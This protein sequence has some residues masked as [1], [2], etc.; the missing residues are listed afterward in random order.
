MTKKKKVLKVG[1]DLDG[2]I[3][4][5]PAR[6]IRPLVSLLK[7][8]K[9]VKRKQLQFF[10]P[11]T[12]WQ[13]LMWCWFHKSSIF[14]APGLDDIRQLVEQNKIEAFIITARFAHLK[15]DFLKWQEKMKAS[16]IFTACYLNEKDEQPHLFK[17]RMIKQLKLDY[18]VE[19]NADIVDYLA[20]KMARDNLSTKIFWVYNLLDKRLKY[21]FKFAGLKKAVLAIK[22]NL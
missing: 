22:E 3:L 4:Y 18:F 14:L 6:I 10:V 19:D 7:K 15:N 20:G 1:F 12:Q 17:E 21:P 5:N 9:L 11:Q 16:E 2:V 8:K 13:Q